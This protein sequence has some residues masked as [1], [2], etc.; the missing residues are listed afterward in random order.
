MNIKEKISHCKW[1]AM[2]ILGFLPIP[3]GAQ[4]MVPPDT[5]QCHIIGF[6]VGMKIPSTQFSTVTLPDGSRNK[7][8]TM[9]SLY[10][11]PYLDFG[12][13]AI[14][15]YRSNW[16][17]LLYG[18]IWFGNNNLKHRQ[19][20]MGSIYSRDSIIIATNGTDANVS[21]YNRGFSV[22][23]GAGK[24]WTVAPEK[25][26]NSGIFTKLTAGYMRQQTI[27]VA[28][29]EKA[30]AVDGDYGL[31]YDHQRHGFLLTEGVGYWFMSNYANLV[32]LYVTFEL[33]QVWSSPTRD[34]TIDYYLGLR[35]KDN[36]RY[37][38]LIYSI[39]LCWMIP[40]KGK[41]SRD[42]YFY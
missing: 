36:N 12:L 3:V 28:N 35:G 25:N 6:D 4:N 9:A 20:R 29:D 23:A 10:K 5:L 14:Y 17:V 37:F 32:N 7:N 41:S 18:D 34:Y 1:V 38:D 40:L 26:P 2:L 31:L 8:A 13:N 22:Q 39:K 24:I 19:E 11:G 33:T 42:Y 27:F 15:K 21:C 30:P 16:M